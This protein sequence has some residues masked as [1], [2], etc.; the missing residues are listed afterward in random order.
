MY[1]DA[2]PITSDNK[3]VATSYNLL[4]AKIGIRQQL[5]SRIDMDAYFGINNITNT[6]YPMMVFVNQ[7]PDAYV[8]APLKAVYFG[9]LNIRYHF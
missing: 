2:V 7:L 5:L 1:K 3:V 9:G 8:P 4:N 6:Q